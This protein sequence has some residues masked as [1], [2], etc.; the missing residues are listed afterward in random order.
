[1]PD[2]I[3]VEV[4]FATPDRQVLVSVELDEG[5][6]VEDAISV[7]GIQSRFAERLDECPVGI[8]GRPV[9][10]SHIVKKGDRIEIYR[11]L[12]RDPRDA[13]RALARIQRFGSSS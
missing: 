13:R 6:T 1:M 10:R 8:W 12:A 5:A 7:S 2:P 4:V 11:P 3:Q 9:E